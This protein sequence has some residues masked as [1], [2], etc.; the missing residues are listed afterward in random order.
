MPYYAIKPIPRYPWRGSAMVV[1]DIGPTRPAGCQAPGPPDCDGTD[2]PPITNTAPRVGR[3][4]HGLTA[5]ES[6]A[7]LQFSEFARIGGAFVNTCGA[8]PCHAAG[9]TGP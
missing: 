8:A 6:A 2:P 1:W 3:D 5:Y 7:Q 4:P 9:W